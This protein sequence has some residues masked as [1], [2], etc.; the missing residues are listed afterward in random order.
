MN[1]KTELILIQVNPIDTYTNL[2]I[3]N[4]N[5]QVAATTKAAMPNERKSKAEPPP[6]KKGKEFKRHKYSIAKTN[7]A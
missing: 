4:S 1:G 2:T 3:N 5:K 6:R 7:F